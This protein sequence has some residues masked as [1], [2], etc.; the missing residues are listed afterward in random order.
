LPLLGTLVV[1]IAL[2]GLFDFLPPMLL[3]LQSVLAPELRN[4]TLAEAE[5]IGRDSGVEVVKAH[6]EPCDTNPRDYVLRQD[7]EPGAVMRRG[8]KVRLT[9]CSGIRV[10]TLVGQREEQARVQL[11]QRGWTVR[12]VRTET[13]SS[14]PPGTITDQ[15]PA[16]DLIIP[17]REPLVLTVAEA[18]KP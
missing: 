5:L 1:V 3:P 4:R 14:V 7:P 15:E 16:A 9:T 17:D 18:P 8:A 2:T 6:P 11:V 10:P 13:T 12:A